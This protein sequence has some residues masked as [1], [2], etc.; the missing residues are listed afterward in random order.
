MR[1]VVALVCVLG[2]SVLGCSAD[3]AVTTARAGSVEG[4]GWTV[5]Q[6]RG[7]RG[8]PGFLDGVDCLTAVSCVAVGNETTN[9]LAKALVETLSGGSWTASQLPLVRG[10]VAEF[11]FSVSCPRSDGCVSVGYSYANQS[12]HPLIESQSG[13]AWSPT[14]PTVPRTLGGFLYGVSCAAPG[15]CVAV[16]NTY[17]ALSR[18]GLP[19]IT[20]PLIVTLK[21]GRWAVTP[22]PGLGPDGGN[23]NAITCSS[24]DA[25]VAV[26]YQQ[27]TKTDGRTLV[28]ELA[29]GTWS[30]VLGTKTSRYTAS[31]GLTGVSCARPGI[32]AAVGQLPGGIPIIEV[33]AKAKW[34]TV[35]TRAPN[36][37]DQASGLAGISCPSTN[38]CIAVGEEAKT[39]PT[40]TYAGA[41]GTPLEALIETGAGRS[42]SLVRAPSQLPPESGLHAITCIGQVCVAVGQS[43]DAYGNSTPPTDTAHTLII[44]AR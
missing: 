13:T 10:S 41:Y 23:L 28:E 39:A 44:Q 42:W 36:P 7:Q 24:P 31:S 8:F 19:A 1:R 3:A 6:A 34:S 43:G 38:H 26:G 20:K 18:P 30:L 27:T 15:A 16:G 25:C 11:L 2:V 21:A 17:S 37:N 5:V 4:S 40:S 14:L 35:P 32:C 22:S 29:D 9:G 33:A 12:G